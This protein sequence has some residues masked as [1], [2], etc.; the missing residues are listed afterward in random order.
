MPPAVF[1]AAPAG[2]PGGLPGT[3]RRSP[4]RQPVGAV[5]PPPGGFEGIGLGLKISQAVYTGFVGAST[6][7]MR[8]GMNSYGPAEGL[9][10]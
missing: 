3:R 10:A 1:L 8:V 2:P 9:R 6:S 4:A 7:P 5:L